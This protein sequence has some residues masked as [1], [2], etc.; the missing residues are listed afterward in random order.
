MPMGINFI[1]DQWARIMPQRVFSPSRFGSR[2]IFAFSRGAFFR[3]DL[4]CNYGGY[5]VNNIF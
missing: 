5:A 1:G 3:E 4:C 2:N